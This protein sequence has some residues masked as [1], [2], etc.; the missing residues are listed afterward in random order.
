MLRD[1]KPYPFML[2][3]DYFCRVR[4]RSALAGQ[5]SVGRAKAGR[6][7]RAV[8]GTTDDVT[9][10]LQ[11]HEIVA[12]DQLGLVHVAELRL[13]SPPTACAGSAAV[14]ERAV[15][16]EPARDLAPASSRQLTTSPRSNSPA[17]PR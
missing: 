4:A 16:H 3:R 13:R 5:R 15:V 2:Y 12:V 10:R 7:L 11:Q 17:A 8:P 1:L 14:S 9:A 6:G